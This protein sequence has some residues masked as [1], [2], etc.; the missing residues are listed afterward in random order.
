MMA[1]NRGVDRRI[2]EYALLESVCDVDSASQIYQ[3]FFNKEP[4]AQLKTEADEDY[5]RKLI[6]AIKKDL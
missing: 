3:Q 5:V 4:P 6:N 2:P 1:M